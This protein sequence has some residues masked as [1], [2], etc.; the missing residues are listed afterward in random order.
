MSDLNDVINYIYFIRL[1]HFKYI[2]RKIKLYHENK[3]IFHFNFKFIYCELN[4]TI[5]SANRVYLKKKC[6]WLFAND[7]NSK[8]IF[9]IKSIQLIK[10]IPAL[11]L[12]QIHYRIYMT[13][14]YLFRIFVF[15]K[16]LYKEI[17]F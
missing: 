4:N 2:E 3:N 8:K 10:N 1:K 9:Q 16:C 12:K 7:T 11:I 13:F 17:N 14:I 15:A 6:H 5:Y